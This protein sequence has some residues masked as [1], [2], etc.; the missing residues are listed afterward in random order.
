MG[1]EMPRENIR[2]PEK[3]LSARQVET[4]TQPGKY[5]DGHGLFLRVAKNGAAMGAAHHHSRQA[6]RAW[7]RQPARRASGEAR[8]LA[9]E[10]RGKAMLGGDPLAEKRAALGR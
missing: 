7:A 4:V 9:L 5:F 2:R 8:K 10:N 6:L 1:D 3:A